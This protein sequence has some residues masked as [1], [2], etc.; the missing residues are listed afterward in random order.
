MHEDYERHG[1]NRILNSTMRCLNIFTDIFRLLPTSAASFSFTQRGISMIASP[2]TFRSSLANSFPNAFQ[3]HTCTLRMAAIFPISQICLSC[4]EPVLKHTE[5][6]I[7]I[8]GSAYPGRT[9]Q[10][11]REQQEKCRPNNEDRNPRRQGKGVNASPL[12][13]LLR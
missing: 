3:V 1:E 4:N 6:L 9:D 8:D 11:H 2:S 7:R 13:I 10:I 5:L 12:N